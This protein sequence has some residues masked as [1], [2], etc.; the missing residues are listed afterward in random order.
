VGRSGRSALPSTET[1]RGDIHEPFRISRTSLLWRCLVSDRNHPDVELLER[2]RDPSDFLCGVLPHAARTFAA[3]IALLPPAEAA[4]SAVAYVYCRVLDT[5]EDHARRALAAEAVPHLVN[6][7]VE[8]I[9]VPRSTRELE[10]GR[11]GTHAA[12]KDDDSFL[13]GPTAVRVSSLAAA[14]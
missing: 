12:T 5:Y 4:A 14:S 6:G 2:T 9:A 8:A 10:R 3:C 7:D 11:E 13:H 1:A